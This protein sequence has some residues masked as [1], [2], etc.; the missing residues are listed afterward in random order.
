MA[1]LAGCPVQSPRMAGRRATMPP[2]LPKRHLE[3]GVTDTPTQAKR[4]LPP[5]S[6]LP[7][8]FPRSIP[9]GLDLWG[10]SS[11]ALPSHFQKGLS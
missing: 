5:I 1:R 2:L 4:L 6:F 9:S 8:F 3:L 7:L 11:S 10:L